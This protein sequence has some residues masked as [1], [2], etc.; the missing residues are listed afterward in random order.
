MIPT[1][2]SSYHFVEPR[3]IQ[4]VDHC[5][6]VRILSSCNEVFFVFA[7]RKRIDDFWKIA[8]M[9]VRKQSSRK[10]GIFPRSGVPNGRNESREFD[11]LGYIA[12]IQVYWR[13]VVW[14]EEF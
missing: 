14:N 6:A 5:V 10:F 13:N 2:S 12:E 9:D 3:Y 8:R 4:M 11:T 7:K 1:S